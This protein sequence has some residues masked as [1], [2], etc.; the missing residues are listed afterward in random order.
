MPDSVE[1]V[2]ESTTPT[3]PVV[4]FYHSHKRVFA[5]PFDARLEIGRQRAGEPEPQ[6]RLERA[7]YTR[8]VLA[9]LDDVDVSRSHLSLE[10]LES[11]VD[12][13][14]KNLS[15]SQP[16]QI[17]PDETLAPGEEQTTQIPLLA[18]FSTYAIRVEPPEEESLVLHA[19]PERTMA[20][21]HQT[22]ET[23]LSRLN[24]DTMDERLLLRWLE[25]VLGVFQSAAN[26]RD[27][28][29]LAAKALVKIVGLDAAAM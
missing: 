20:P 4:L 22:L 14:V 6:R 5:T 18:Q 1:T 11:G 7:D 27:F 25:T 13:K 19:L 9:P 24:I 8:V 29:E 21:G 17:S 2:E 3:I 23:G 28:P 26:S 16:V 12:V 15:R 10:L